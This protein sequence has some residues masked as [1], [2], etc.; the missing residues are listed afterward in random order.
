VPETF[1]YRRRYFT[2]TFSYGDVLYRDVLS[3]RRF[4]LRR[5]VCAPSKY[6]FWCRNLGFLFNKLNSK[7]VG[8]LFGSF[9]Q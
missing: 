5:F 6:L 7:K 8:A 3:R 1:C 2:E 9:L 4:V